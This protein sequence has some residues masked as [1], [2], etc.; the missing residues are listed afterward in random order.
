MT[1]ELKK[2]IVTSIVLLTIVLNCLYINNFS[3]LILICIVSFFSWLEF[4]NIVKKIRVNS[5]LKGI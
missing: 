2:R 5:F 1:K 3:W 4:F